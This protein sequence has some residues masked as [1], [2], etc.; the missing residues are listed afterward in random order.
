MYKALLDTC[1]LWPSLQRDFLL[2]LAA[3]GLYAPVLSEGILGELEYHE[4]LK[5]LERSGLSPDEAAGKARHLAAAM[6]EAFAD[7]IVHGWEGLEGSL[8]LPDPDDEHVIAAAVIAGAGAIVTE[9]L[10]DFP[11]GCVPAGIQVVPARIFLF[12]TVSLRPS[13]GAKAVTTMAERSGRVHEKKAPLQILDDLDRLYGLRDC[14]RLIRLEMGLE[15][16]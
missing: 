13:L 6:R 11:E 2:S 9:N 1:V 4:E 15:S 8:G 14:T 5:H 7:S 12:E 3:E 16:V 10:R